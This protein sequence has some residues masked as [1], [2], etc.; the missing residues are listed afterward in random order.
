LIGLGLVGFGIG[1]GLGGGGIFNA[2]SSNEGSG[3]ASFA[4]QVK[5]YR[6]QTQ[7]QPQNP[8]GYEGLAKALLHEAGG[9]GFTTATGTV[10]KKGK[11]LFRE[12]S[13]AWSAYLA[14]NPPKPNP[15]LAQLIVR[16]YGEEGLNQPA[17]AVEALQLV[18]AARPTSAAYYAQLAEFA[19]KAG[20]VRVGDLAS[21]KAVALAPVETRV[22]I[23]KELAEVKKYPHGGQSFVTTTN[24]KTYRLKK[25]PSGEFT[26]TQI[27]STPAPSTAATPTTS[28]PAK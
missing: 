9:E 10:T 11:E 24:G 1:G 12:A 17:K 5:K 19:Y 22:R 18:V 20:N 26:G 2:A 7:T 23:K 6:K 27:T 13:E 15:E 21:A 3:G 16:I 8:A 28:T 14:L 4:A 25:S